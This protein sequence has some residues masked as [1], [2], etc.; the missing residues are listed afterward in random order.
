MK[1][2]ENCENFDDG[3]TQ[4]APKGEFKAGKEF[5]LSEKRYR[6]IEGV[7]YPEEDVKEFIRLLEE[8]LTDKEFIGMWQSMRIFQVQEQIKYVIDKLA[9]DKLK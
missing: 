9:G 7:V 6:D 8:E 1:T 3:I 2:K 5:N 4:V